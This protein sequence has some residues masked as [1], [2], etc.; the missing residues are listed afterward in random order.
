MIGG[1]YIM[2]TIGRAFARM[3]ELLSNTTRIA[4]I[5]TQ[6]DQVGTLMKS[7]SSMLGTVEQQAMDQHLRHAA[8]RGVPRAR[9]T[10]AKLKE[11][12]FKDEVTGLYN[13]RFFSLRLEE[14]ISRFQAVQPPGIRGRAGCGRVQKRQ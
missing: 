13:R 2:W 9:A 5:G 14:E 6:S 7:F 4:E 8:R 10:N 1:A 3:A 11:T 12:S